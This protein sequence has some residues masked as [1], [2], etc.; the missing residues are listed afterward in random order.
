MISKKNIDNGSGF[1][2]GLASSDY[3]TILDLKKKSE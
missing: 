1:D 3:P 2:W